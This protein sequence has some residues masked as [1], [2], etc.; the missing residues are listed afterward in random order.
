MLCDHNSEGVVSGTCLG[1][2]DTIT[3]TDVL[4]ATELTKAFTTF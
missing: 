1:H 3:E 2:Y 4:T